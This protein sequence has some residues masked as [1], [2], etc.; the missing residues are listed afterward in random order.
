MEMVIQ[1]YI[2]LVDNVSV[3]LT[4]TVSFVMQIGSNELLIN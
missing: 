1:S 4:F 3:I 2:T